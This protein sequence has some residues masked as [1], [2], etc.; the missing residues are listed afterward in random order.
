MKAILYVILPILCVVPSGVTAADAKEE[1]RKI[2]AERMAEMRRRAERRDDRRD[3]SVQ[4]IEPKP[5]PF[6]GE[7]AAVDPAQRTFSFKGKNGKERVF[8]VPA[9]AVVMKDNVRTEFGA[10]VPGVYA[11]GQYTRTEA[12]QE[13]AVSVKIGPKPET[14]AKGDDRPGSRR[15]SMRER[16]MMMDK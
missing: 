3:R 8:T 13:Q 12:G 7:V 2:R 14:V 6:H 9:G 11:T 15:E 10:I 4:R 1:Q 5:I 16:M